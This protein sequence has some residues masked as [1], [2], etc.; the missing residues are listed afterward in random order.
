MSSIASGREP[1]ARRA[2]ASSS[3]AWSASGCRR[4]TFSSSGPAPAR[5]ARAAPC[6]ALAPLRAAGT[7]RPPADR[8]PRPRGRGTRQRARPLQQRLAVER[9]VA[10]ASRFMRRKRASLPVVVPDLGAVVR[11]HVGLAGCAR[12]RRAATWF[13]QVLEW[14]WT[15]SRLA[16]Q[17]RRLP[18]GLGGLQRL[19]AAAWRAAPRAPRRTKATP[20]RAWPVSERQEV[21][22]VA[23]RRAGPRRAGAGRSA[24]AAWCGGRCGV[25]IEHASCGRRS[26]C[27]AANSA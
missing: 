19:R 18:P 26:D 12:A 22:L 5:V 7:R 14:T 15:T 9:H 17:R 16:H 23:A 21:D 4:L 3:V 27:R 2:N 13:I 6:S 10:R 20:S 11:E 1:R 8:R 24:L 25:T